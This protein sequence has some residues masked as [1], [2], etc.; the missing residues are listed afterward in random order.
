M[1]VRIGSATLVVCLALV[2]ACSPRTDVAPGIAHPAA[3]AS[4]GFVLEDGETVHT[5]NDLNIVLPS[6][7]EALVSGA[8]LT[9]ADVSVASESASGQPDCPSAALRIR[10]DAAESGVIDTE[11]I[12]LSEA[13]GWWRPETRCPSGQSAGTEPIVA[14]PIGGDTFTTVTGEEVKAGGWRL[15]CADGVEFDSRIWYVPDADVEFAVGAMAE[16]VPAEEYE[17][18]VRSLDLSDYVD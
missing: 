11:G 2:V 12:R 9:P 18:V 1:R 17:R 5:Y 13:G 7:W 15:T 16:E 6:G 8:C 10:V 14:D 4:D 3:S